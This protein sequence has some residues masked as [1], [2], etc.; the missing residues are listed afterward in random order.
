MNGPTAGSPFDA[1]PGAGAGGLISNLRQAYEE[2]RRPADAAS[3]PRQPRAD[4]RAAVL[5]ILA[6]ESLNGYQIVRAIEERSTGAWTPG[7]GAVYPVLQLLS[8]ERLVTAVESDGRK[9]WSL[10]DAGRVAAATVQD[11]FA[12]QEAPGTRVSPRRGAVSRAAAQ[13]VQ[14]AVLVAQ[15]GTPQQVGDAVGVLDDARRRLIAILAR[16]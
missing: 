2:L 15:T 4:V 10:T 12:A 13:L 1:R 5:R 16:N 6:D 7:A 8:D 14:T 3:A 11:P 9:T